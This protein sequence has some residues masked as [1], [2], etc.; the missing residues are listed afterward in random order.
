MNSSPKSAASYGSSGS[1]RTGLEARLVARPDG[2]PALDDFEIVEVTVPDP[3]AGQVLVRNLFMS[4]D[5]GMLL[6]MG[7]DS[8]LPAPRYEIGAAMYGDA[9]GEVIAS[10]DPSL[11]E[12]DLVVHRLGWR[13][14]AVA[15]AAAFRRVDRAAYPSPSLHLG[16]GLV[17]YVGLMEAAQLRPGDTVFRVLA[18]VRR[19]LR[20]RRTTG[21][22]TGGEDRGSHQDARRPRPSDALVGRGRRGRGRTGRLIRA[23]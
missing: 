14:Y 10:A 20:R 11:S 18:V 19:G 13:D 3:A 21:G 17:A 7:G 8:P 4:L 12:G 5:P 2:L 15:A 6:L 9:V 23:G 1:P 22:R 16:F